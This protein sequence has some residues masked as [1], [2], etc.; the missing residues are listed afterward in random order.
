MK[1]TVRLSFDVPAEEHILYKTECVKS[2][3]PIK[4]FLHNLVILGMHEY[5]KAKFN[6]RMEKSIKQAKRGK[7]RKITSEDLDKWEKELDD[8]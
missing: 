2:R 1:S 4:D 6:K 3:V 8:A 5:E 7:T